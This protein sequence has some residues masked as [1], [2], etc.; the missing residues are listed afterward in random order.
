MNIISIRIS[1]IFQTC[2]EKIS[3]G[4]LPKVHVYTEQENFV[5]QS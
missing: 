1:Y 3:K 4:F 2:I 5:L